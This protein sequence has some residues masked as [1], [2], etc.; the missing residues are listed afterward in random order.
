MNMLGIVALTGFVLVTSA[1]RPSRAQQACLHKEFETAVQRERRDEALRA[2]R[3]INSANAMQGRFGRPY[4]PWEELAANAGNLRMD[5]G[6]MGRLARKMQWGA[7]E[8]L[9]GWTIYYLAAENGYAFSLRDALDP[10]G[11][12]YVS[13]DRG[14]IVAGEAIEPRTRVIPTEGG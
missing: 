2:V 4:P 1:G 11:F 8:P 9:P 5:G 6:P 14:V 12:T 13:D 3:L 10:C 7:R